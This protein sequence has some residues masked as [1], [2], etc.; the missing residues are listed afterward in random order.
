MMTALS[1]PKEKEALQKKMRDKIEAIQITMLLGVSD[2]IRRQRNELGHPREHPPQLSRGDAHTNLLIF[3][4]YYE[5]AEAV[6]RVLAANK[7]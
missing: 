6:R 2:F 3:P 7:V 1:S 5:T 4:G